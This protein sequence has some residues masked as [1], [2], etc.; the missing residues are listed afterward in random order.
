LLSHLSA[1]QS[2]QHGSSQTYESKVGEA[3][4]TLADGQHPQAAVKLPAA[5]ADLQEARVHHKRHHS[6]RQGPVLFNNY[7]QFQS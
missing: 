6:G 5:Q 7:E 2:A 1:L 4:I 3:V